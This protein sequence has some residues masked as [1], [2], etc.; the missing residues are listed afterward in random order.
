[1]ARV[2]SPKGPTLFYLRYL[3]AELRRRKGRTVLTAACLAVGIA[4]VVAVTSLS[5]GLDDAQGEVLDPL[6][7]VGTEMTVTRPISLPDPSE[8]GGPPQL[9]KQE[10]KQL[11]REGGGPPV[12]LDDLGKAGSKFDTY[13]YRSTDLSFPAAKTKQIAGVDGVEST[14]AGLTVDVTHISGTVPESSGSDDASTAPGGFPAAGGDPAAGGGPTSIDF[15][16]LSVSGVDVSNPDLGLVTSDQIVKGDYFSGN[17]K[18]QAILS[19]AYAN[20]NDIGVGD[21]VSVGKQKLEVVGIS[22]GAVGGESSDVYMELAALQKAADLEGRVNAV[23]VQAASADQVDAVADQIES[24]FANSSVTTAS[25]VADQVSGSLVD[26]K[27]LSGKLGTALAIVALIGAFGIAALVTLSSVNKRTRELGTLKALGWK[28]WLVVRQ[29]AGESVVQGLLGGIAGVVL[30][31]AAAAA[32]GA[33]GISLDATL[34]TAS[35]AGGFPGAPGGGG[36]PGTEQAADVVNTVTLG[37]PVSLGVI[38]A[39]VGLAVIGGLLAGAVGGMRAARLRPA[40]ALRSV[41]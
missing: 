34:A 40:E 5:A 6:T 15:D 29:I 17:G 4:L 7:G 2:N 14:A 37:A 8:G 33:A 3:G 19:Q 24:T 1:M 21:T 35:Q 41:E 27:N 10:Q 32:I 26:A 31:L 23:Q 12:A 11:E 28:R 9:S 36:P 22:G 13:Q 38:A 39:A 25:D 16:S 18:G 20:E 30:G